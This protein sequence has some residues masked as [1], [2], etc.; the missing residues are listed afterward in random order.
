MLDQQ[1]GDFFQLLEYVV[2]VRVVVDEALHLI[3][4]LPH[5]F[6]QH[7]DRVVALVDRCEQR[8]RVDQQLVD[9]RAA[10]AEDARDLVRVGEQVFDLVVAL[11]DGVGEPGGGGGGFVP[12]GWGWV[13][14]GPRMVPVG[15]DAGVWVPIWFPSTPNPLPSLPRSMDMDRPFPTPTP[16]MRPLSLLLSPPV[17]E[18][19]A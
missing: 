15:M 2:E 18:N 5:P 4:E 19:W 11:A 12:R 1:A 13:W 14:R 6:E 8:L 7:A 3:G 10:V 16:G 9:L 17:S